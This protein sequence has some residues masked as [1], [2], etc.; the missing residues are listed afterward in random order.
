MARLD[1][2]VIAWF[3]QRYPEDYQTAMNAALRAS[4]ESH[5]EE[6]DDLDHRKT[7]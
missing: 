3:R 1:T 2:D 7:A 5:D 4:I 6:R